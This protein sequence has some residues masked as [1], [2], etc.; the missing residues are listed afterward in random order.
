MADEDLRRG[1]AEQQPDREREQAD[2]DRLADDQRRDP[3]VLQPTARR[4]PI[5]RIRSNTDIAIVFVTPIPPTI[6][7]SSDDDPAGWR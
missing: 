2:P 7:A 3:P 5:S 6:S 4:S 1:V